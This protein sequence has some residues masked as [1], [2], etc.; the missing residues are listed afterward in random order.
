MSWHDGIRRQLSE[1]LGSRADNEINQLNNALRLLAKHRSVKL[2]ASC[3]QKIDPPGFALESFDVM[4]QRRSHYRILDPKQREVIV[5]YFSHRLPVIKYR[6][7]SEVKTS[8]QLQ[9]GFRFEDVRQLKRH[10]SRNAEA[11]ARNLVERLIVYSSGAPVGY[12]DRA[13]VN[14]ILDKTREGAFGL[15]SIL[16][17]VV[18][19]D[20]FRT[21]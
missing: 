6:K 15:R 21:K 19:S 9:D 4:G 11:L 13:A 12:A 8:D 3:H 20:L 7:G 5:R 14:Q 1:G 17:E 18:Q 2:C 16:Y 10:F